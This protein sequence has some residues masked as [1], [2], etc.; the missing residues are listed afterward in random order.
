MSNIVNITITGGAG[1]IVYSLVPLILTGQIYGPKTLINL[2]L[3]DIPAAADRL[4]GVELEIEDSGFTLLNNLVCTTDS[5]VAFKDC[6]VAIILGGFPRLPGMERKELLEKNAE[7][8]LSQAQA[9][10]KY[11]NKNTKVVVVANPANTNCLIMAKNCPNIPSENF[12][13][14]TRLDEERLK[15]YLIKKLSS[16]LNKKVDKKL[17]N[18]VFILGNHSTTQIPCVFNGV[19]TDEFNEGVS[20]KISNY[21][22]PASDSEFKE[23][24]T[25]I[26]NRGAEIIKYLQLSSALS[27][28]QAITYHLRDWIG[29]SNSPNTVFSMGVINNNNN[30]NVPND[31]VFSVPC[32]RDETKECGYRVVDELL[33]TFPEEIKERITLTIE[34]LEGEKSQILNFI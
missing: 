23:L 3:L 1:R 10:N 33:T 24:L 30:Y 5:E 15:N 2:R 12:T 6:D 14:L 21:F 29:N 18:N 27:A 9:L 25:T 26:Q 7:S 11:G 20:D 4:H 17:L 8:M 19:I 13:C 31:I 32:I 22:N 28:A 16:K 34:E